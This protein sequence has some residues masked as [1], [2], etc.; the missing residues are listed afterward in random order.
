MTRS[1]WV[2]AGIAGLA[3]AAS[4][5]G[6]VAAAAA[7]AAPK[8]SRCPDAAKG[9]NP[10]ECADIRV[11]LSWADPHGRSISLHLSRL[12][13]LDK[14]HRLGSLLFNPG[15][16]GGEGAES[17]SEYGRVLLPKALQDRFDI[18]GFD[19]RGV[20]KSTAV[21]CGGPGLSPRVPVFPKN[22][23]QFAAIQRQSRTYGTSCVKHSAPGLV[24]NVD[25][26][27]AARDMDAIR[28]A[29]GEK[30]ISF[31][32]VSYGTFLGQTYA[33]LFPQRVGTMVLDGA[34]DH[35]VGPRAFLYQEA[36][37]VSRVFGLFARWCSA[38][39]SCALHGQNVTK[40][41]DDLLA[42]AAREPIPAPHAQGGA[43]RVNDEAIRMVLTNLL[44]LGP[45]STV[46]PSTWPALGDAIAR[47]RA[48]DASAMADNSAVGQPQ[49]AY[50][51]IGCQDFPP[52]LRGYA[53]AAARLKHVRALSPHTGGAS[54]AWLMTDLCASWPL[55]ASDPWTA[56]RI[57][58]VPPV[59]VASTRHDPSTPLVWAQGLHREIA[60]SGLLVADVIGHTAFFNSACAR[61]AEAG[62][63]I[64]GRLPS[65]H[66]TA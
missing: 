54:E 44:L 58:G 59:L 6:A 41:W 7:P 5:S 24:A 16:P 63:L 64:S 12:P 65:V 43:T 14:R 52:Q 61:D 47:A 34:M 23:T 31:L 18:V 53:D 50:A 57:T 37:E 45:T 32:G 33:R 1:R 9:P 3:A 35:A 27:S 20:G 62:Y 17:I 55:P 13:A 36:S 26:P 66:C 48:G 4:L 2:A 38:T 42:R 60:G 46:L 21:S 25:T 22:G 40:V 51:A 28:V 8:W 49:D 39:T 29:L 56:R 10:A 15:G 11:P 30:K 19:P